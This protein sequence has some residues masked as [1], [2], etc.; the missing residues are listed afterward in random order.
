M[1]KNTIE[2]T[3]KPVVRNEFILELMLL[4]RKEHKRKI[5]TCIFLENFEKLITLVREKKLFFIVLQIYL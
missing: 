2:L 4:C 1:I 3:V 5:E